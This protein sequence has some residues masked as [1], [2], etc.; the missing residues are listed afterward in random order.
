MER[1]YIQGKMKGHHVRFLVDSGAG[2]SCITMKWL[3]KLGIERKDLRPSRGISVVRGVG[4]E[5]HNVVGMIN[6]EICISGIKLYQSFHVF[7]NL[8]TPVILGYDFLESHK[9]KID[10]EN[11]VLEI[12]D[13]MTAIAFLNK[14]Y[15]GLARTTSPVIIPPRAHC[16]FPVRVSKLKEGTVAL[17]EPVSSLSSKKY[18]VGAKSLVT[19]NKGKASCMVMNPTKATVYLN[20]GC[21][22]ATA[23]IIDENNVEPFEDDDPIGDQLPDE[24]VSNVNAEN[25]CTDEEYIKIARELGVQLGNATLNEDQKRKLLILLGKYRKVFAKGLPEVGKTEMYYHNIDT[26]D[27]EPIS[28]RFYR[29]TPVMRRETERQIEEML[30]NDII[31]NSNSEWHAPVVLV[32]KKNN[33]W[34]FCI[35]YRRLNAVT[36]TKVFPLPRM[37][38]MFQA[39]GESKPQFLTIL[40]LASGFWQIPLDKQSREKTAFITEG[41]LYHFK[42]LPYGMKNSSSTFQRL[43]AEVLRDINWKFCLV[44]IDDILIFSKDFDSHLDHLSQV[45]DRL[46]KANLTLKISKCEFA[47]TSVSYLGHTISKDGIAV[48]PA[49]TKVIREFPTPRHANDVR[50]FLGMC[51]FFRK[52]IPKFA[53]IANPLNQLLRKDAKFQWTDAC[54]EAFDT[55]KQKLVEP[56]VLAFADLSLSFQLSTDSSNHAIGYVLEQKDEHGRPRAIAYG[57]RSLRGSEIAWSI[58][59]KEC[60][61]VI[62]GIKAYHHYLANDHFDVYTDHIA[63]KWLQSIK[64][65]TG[66]LARWSLMLQG[67]NFTIHHRPG[68]KNTVADAL[69][70]REYKEKSEETDSDE[71]E[72]ENILT[73]HTEVPESKWEEYTFTYDT[74][75]SKTAETFTEI[76]NFPETPTLENE[77]QDQ[78]VAEVTDLRTMQR[79]CPDC[80]PMIKYLEDDELPDNVRHAKR[81]TVEADNYITD[82]GILYHLYYRRAKGLPKPERLI[83]QLVV[84]RPLRAQALQAYHDLL[85]GG[86]HQGFERT[87]HSLRNKYYWPKMYRDVYEHVHSCIEC[88]QAKSKPSVTPAPLHPLPIADIFSRWHMD[89]QGPLTTSDQGY[90]HILVIT[91]SFSKWCEAIPTKTQEAKEVAEVLYRD[92]FTRYGAPHTLVSDR[93]RNF[94]STLVQALCTLFDIKRVHTSSYHPQTNSAVERMNSVIA[95]SIRTYGKLDQKNWPDLLPGIM[96]AY[97]ATPATQSTHL[98]PYFMVFGR[99]MNLPFDIEWIPKPNMPFTAQKHLEKV[100]DNLENARTIAS[101]NMEKAQV[102]YKKYYDQKAKEPKFSPGD[103]VWLYNIKVPIGLSKKLHRKWTGPFYITQMGPNHTYKLRQCSDNK[104]VKS[105]THANRLKMFYDPTSRPVQS[106]FQIAKA[107]VNDE[108]DDDETQP[109]I[110]NTA[111]NRQTQDDPRDNENNANK[112]KEGTWHTID[113]ICA[114]KRQNGKVYYRVKWADIPQTEW[115]LSENVSDFAKQEFHVNRTASGKRRKRPLGKHNFFTPAR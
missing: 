96:M 19:V 25:V 58:S 92:I 104:E 36:K 23:T 63:L 3:K 38:D 43:M 18:L 105:L 8:Y 28:Q 9:A 82:D 65:T 86:G 88:Q 49:K 52:F 13:G 24:H 108:R 74:E 80:V 90:K 106:P 66:R 10:I 83:K 67:Y 16:N 6:L 46:R 77:I 89:F 12:Y 97:R 81:I 48:D 2:V 33:E 111:D 62:E 64:Q 102:R 53:H 29:Q 37:E 45:F 27:A 72:K 56:P 5:I 57:G 26:R 93:G 34:R 32:R 60:L 40:D 112:D 54:Q 30:K 1:N 70:R 31:E 11:K 114:F 68:K 20:S 91:D 50:S 17:L 103:R 75:A 95:Q 109:D 35:D 115:V 113:R 101:K 4:G 69:S 110:P 71:F 21:V 41:G 73:V 39:V 107:N 14:D 51:N 98:S 59:D 44:Y 55:L 42:R 100:L 47:T 94:M 85:I 78:L 7:N 99:E 79:E 84:P 22:I 87:Y 61:A 15:L 76:P